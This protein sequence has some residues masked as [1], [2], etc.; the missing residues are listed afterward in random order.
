MWDIIGNETTAEGNLRELLEV[1][2]E[3]ERMKKD[4]FPILNM[5]VTK[6]GKLTLVM[7]FIL[8]LLQQVYWNC[9]SK[10]QSLV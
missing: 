7:F 8:K 6:T 3:T 9:W 10:I 5:K 1:D 2:E 4:T